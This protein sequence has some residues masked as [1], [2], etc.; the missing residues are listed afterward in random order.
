M[1][2]D[3]EL[4]SPN[5]QIQSY[6]GQVKE[7]IENTLERFAKKFE[8]PDTQF[9]QVTIP[10]EELLK[11]TQGQFEYLQRNCTDKELS[12]YVNESLSWT[13]EALDLGLFSYEFLLKDKAHSYRDIRQP[14]ESIVNFVQ[15]SQ[16]Q[17]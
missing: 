4:N 5:S 14:Q 17:T 1:Q 7:L 6:R 2:E 16:G 12:S 8:Q 11:L 9:H 3:L 13:Y 15:E 10:K